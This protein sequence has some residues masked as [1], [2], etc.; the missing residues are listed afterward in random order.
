MSGLFDQDGPSEEGSVVG[1][2]MTR[3]LEL[4]KAQ[5]RGAK[6]GKAI[7]QVEN[8]LIATLKE[9]QERREK[10]NGLLLSNLLL[11]L[12]RPVWN[13]PARNEEVDYGD[14]RRI[15]YRD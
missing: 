2:L 9:Q 11:L 13:G 5:N 3:L 10:K 15:T 4:Y 14:V 12:M 7:V 1:P 8:S 6:N